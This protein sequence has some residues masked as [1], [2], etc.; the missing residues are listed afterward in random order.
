MRGLTSSTHFSSTAMEVRVDSISNLSVCLSTV[1]WRG[2]AAIVGAKEAIALLRARGK[3]VIFVAG[4]A[5]EVSAQGFENFGLQDNGK[6]TLPHPFQVDPSVGA[7]VIGLDRDP[8]YPTDGAILPGGGACVAALQTAVGR[9]P[10][11]IIGKPNQAL[12]QTILSTHS[13]DPSRTCMELEC[14]MERVAL[15]FKCIELQH[16]LDE[17]RR[18]HRRR[19]VGRA[20]IALAESLDRT[21]V[22]Q[23]KLERDERERLRSEREH[24]AEV[25]RLA[26]QEA[27][28]KEVQQMAEE[29]H[30]MEEAEAA[31]KRQKQQEKLRVAKELAAKQQ[32][33]DAALR[34]VEADDRRQRQLEKAAAQV[35]REVAATQQAAEDERMKRKADEKR[36]EV[37]RKAAPSKAA[38][39]ATTTTP[40]TSIS[41]T[42]SKPAKKRK[43]L[44][45]ATDDE[46]APLERPIS[47][48]KKQKKQNIAAAGS[49]KD[50]MQV[51]N[52]VARL[53][54]VEPPAKDDVDGMSDAGP[55]KK[56]KK[57]AGM[58]KQ[59]A[60]QELQR[61]KDAARKLK[62]D[63]K[64]AAKQHKADAKVLKKDQ[65]PI[66]K[67]STKK[68]SK[69]P[70]TDQPPLDS[71]EDDAAMAPLVVQPT[72]PAKQ[73][74][75]P[76]DDSSDDEAAGLSLFDRMAQKMRQQIL[77]KDNSTTPPL[78]SQ[79]PKPARQPPPPPSVAADATPKRSILSTI[80][81]L[82]Q[83]KKP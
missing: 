44:Q 16:S 31:K 68:P 79:M 57:K 23:R 71:S 36:A 73:H 1:L 52:G 37:Q 10:D 58:M 56:K 5:T 38:D 75:E 25:A 45:V 60:A 32:H 21:L 70:T 47:V 77:A 3:K 41:T 34:R 14:H 64:A 7:V 72:K 24:A 67:K 63:Q 82:P 40:D 39:Q 80:F 17:H 81:S 43:K 51:K 19:V 27:R 50:D 55:Q 8:T 66:K 46:A 9:E 53:E 83:L 20:A 33:D 13:L 76:A 65:L 61:K 30:K 62:A 35:E 18:R 26:R 69:K 78:S 6:T 54:H 4:L 22:E 2:D 59:L 29:K 15:D 49:S 42:Q 74:W 12:L 28:D 48:V 11:A